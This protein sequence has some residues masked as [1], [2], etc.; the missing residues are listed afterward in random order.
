MILKLYQKIRK[1]T[2]STIGNIFRSSEGTLLNDNQDICKEFSKHFLSKYSS[3]SFP[4]YESV[5]TSF[6]ITNSLNEII[7]TK[8]DVLREILNF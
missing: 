6:P 4:D 7:I 8:T 5:S 1:N 2:D 3:L